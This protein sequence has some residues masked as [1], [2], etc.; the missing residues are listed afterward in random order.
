M[1]FKQYQ[2]ITHKD[3][4]PRDP[5]TDHRKQYG[6]WTE[7]ANGRLNNYTDERPRV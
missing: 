4:T 7:M 5:T 6:K 3:L 2:L 1:T